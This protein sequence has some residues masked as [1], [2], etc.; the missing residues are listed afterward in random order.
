MSELIYRVDANDTFVFIGEGWNQFAAENGLPRLTGERLLKASLWD[1][2]SDLTTRHIYRIWM[3]RVRQT[4]RSVSVPFRCDAP[5]R[6]RF[7]RMT[8]RLRPGDE[9]EFCSETLREETRPS[10]KVLD[11]SHPRHNEF[12]VMCSWCKKIKAPDWVELEQGITQLGL[13]DA[14]RLPCVSHGICP[15]CEHYLQAHS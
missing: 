2:L 14:P 12:I 13:L 11:L 6:R 7:M 9:I 1:F 8:I 4:S 10:V 5:D 3:H 15:E